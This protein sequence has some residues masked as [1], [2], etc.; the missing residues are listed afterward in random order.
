MVH[1]G[2]SNFEK[3]KNTYIFTKFVLNKIINYKKRF[4][5]ICI[6][7]IQ[8]YNLK[9]N[10]LILIFIF[11]DIQIIRSFGPLWYILLYTLACIYFWQ[12]ENLIMH[13]Y[14][15]PSFSV[16]WTIKFRVRGSCHEKNPWA[17]VSKPL[18]FYL[19]SR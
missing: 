9:K 8:G 13:N 16:P 5:Y 11:R 17:T 2:T 6:K 3:I 19:F 12:K 10:N 4:L 15:K 18:V 14:R 1:I 7:N